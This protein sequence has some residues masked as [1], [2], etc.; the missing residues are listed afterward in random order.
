M[1]VEYDEAIKKWREESDKA[2]ANGAVPRPSPPVPDA[3][4]EYRIAASIYDGMIAPLIPFAIRG[5][6]WYQGESN[7]ARAQQYEILLP[8]MIKAW[9]ER[10]NDGDFPFAIVQ[11][12]NYRD[13]K[14]EPVDEAWSHIREAQRRTAHALPNVGLI[15]TIDIGEARDIHPKN[16]L[17]VGKRMA[18][19]ALNSIYAKK[20]T[21]PGPTFKSAKPSDSGNELLVTF[22]DVGRG[23]KTRDSGKPA[24]FAIAGED[25]KWYWAEAE[26]VGKNQVRVWSKSVAK[27][28]AVRYAFNNNPRNPNLTNNSGLPAEPFRSDNWPGPTDGKR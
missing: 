4:R 3:L 10:W 2:K 13:S 8:V 7:E 27:P 25:H 26:I 17:D 22:M 9:R 6:A 23:L 15:V 11:L 20:S 5:A 28:V 1:K 16:K 14:D 24:E 18:Y 12:P 21:E 19:W